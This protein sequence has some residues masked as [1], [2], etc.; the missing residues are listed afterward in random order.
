MP[1]QRPVQ[2]R[3]AVSFSGHAFTVMKANL[4]ELLLLV[5]GSSSVPG[6]P[7]N[8]G[9]PIPVY[10]SLF[11]FDF[12]RSSCRRDSSPIRLTMSL[13]LVRTTASNT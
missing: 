6:A 3:D 9:F 10:R 5:V 4:L 12:F 11:F 8:A 2:A 7:W 13:A 1:T